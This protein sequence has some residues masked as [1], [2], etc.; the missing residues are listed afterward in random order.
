LPFLIAGFYAKRCG[1]RY[2]VTTPIGRNLTR[3]LIRTLPFALLAA[4]VL[5]AQ[6]HVTVT[7]DVSKPTRRFEPVWAWVGHD[8]PNY[9]YSEEGRELLTRLA[10]LSAYPIHD[11]THNLLTS[12]DGTPALKWGSTNAFTRDAS[13]KPVYNWRIVDQIFDTYQA[14][15]ITP[16]VEIG[17]MPEALSPHPEPY[18]H[19][20]PKDFDTGW[21]YPP[22]NYQ[23]WSDLIYS[24]VRHMADRYGTDQAARWEW[25]VWNEPDIFYWHGTVDDYNKFYDYTVAAVRRALPNARVGGPATTGPASQRAA[26]FLRAFLEHCASGQNYATGKKGAPLDFIS[27]HAKGS[28]KVVDGHVELN[29]GTNLRDIDQGFAIIETF[30]AFCQLPVV[31]SE[32][33]PESCAACD[34]MSHPQNEYRL[35]SQYASYEAELLHGTLALAERHHI[36]LEGTIAWAFTFPGQPIFSGLRAF[37]TNAIDLPVLNAFRMFGLMKGARVAAESTGALAVGDVLESSVKANPDVKAI[38]THDSHRVNALVWSYHDDSNQSAPA[39]IRLR[40]DGLPQGVSRVL[41][42]HWGVD[43]DHSNSYTA[44][45][46][47]GSPQNP[48]ADEYERLKA[49]GQLQLRES[50]RWIVADGGTV[51]ITFTQLAQGLSLLDLTW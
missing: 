11:R 40:I 1:S 9:T 45:K 22:N 36:N 7:V 23:E 27:F 31:L 35:T 50:P 33:D 21:A 6:Q 17:F 16:L 44:W 32:S 51:E 12:G 28:A 2:T 8:E 15:G 38:A 48:S 41:L 20:W 24:W 29:V 47:M 5:S 10:R 13:G 25:E 49:A 46:T 43:R 30:P 39:E 19:H 37:T 3:K 18:R 14:T 4:V 34:A 26:E 42:E